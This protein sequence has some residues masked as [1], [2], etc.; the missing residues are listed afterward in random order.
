MQEKSP[1]HRMLKV[2]KPQVLYDSFKGMYQNAAVVNAL[3]LMV[4]ISPPVKMDNRSIWIGTSHED[5]IEQKLAFL[6][7]LVSCT[8]LLG[9]F[10]GIIMGLALG[11]IPHQHSPLYMRTA[12]RFAGRFF[13]QLGSVLMPALLSAFICLRS[14]IITPAA[15]IKSEMSLVLLF[16]LVYICLIYFNVVAHQA[17]FRVFSKIEEEKAKALGTDLADALRAHAGEA[18]TDKYIDTFLAQNVA[19]VHL[20]QM[21]FVHLQALGVTVGD[22]M[23]FLSSDGQP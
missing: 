6:R 4:S 2:M 12:G 10:H 5:T 11:G 15:D 14:S 23:N 21:T 16:A 13:P 19:G 20:K 9:L 8:A 1:W 7:A 3:C 22:A 18:F 17:S